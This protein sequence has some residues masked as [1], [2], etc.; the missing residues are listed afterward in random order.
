MTGARVVKEE[1][2]GDLKLYRVPDRTSV[3]SRQLK[4][5]RLLDR[6]SVSFDMVYH[7]DLLGN[8][9]S[10]PSPPRN[11]CAPETTPPITWACRY[12]RDS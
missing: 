6:G 9:T 8:T 2:L 3:T 4:Q 12:P 7:A 1:Q 5:V 11:S 10:T